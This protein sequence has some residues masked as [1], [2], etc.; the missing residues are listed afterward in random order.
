MTFTYALLAHQGGWDE[1]LLVVGPIA[2]I[3]GLLAVVRRRVGRITHT[4]TGTGRDSDRDSGRDSDISRGD[5]LDR[6]AE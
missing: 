1:I 6:S 3:L 4:G 5:P 2:V